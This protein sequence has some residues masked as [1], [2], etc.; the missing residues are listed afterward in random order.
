M[1]PPRR[2]R[3]LLLDFDG[4]LAQYSRPIR[5]ARLAEHAGCS[6][7]DVHQ[8][9][10]ASGLETAYDG[11]ELDTADYL[12][13]LGVA[14]GRPVDEATWLT[15]RV[16]ACR[17]FSEVVDAAA[18]L[19]QAMPVAI[20]TNNGPLITQAIEQIVP[21][22]VPALAGRVF[23]SAQFGGRKPQREVFLQALEAMGAEPRESLFI[24]DL[25]VNVRGARAA[26]LHAETSRDVRSFR[27]VLSRYQLAA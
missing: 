11:G 10:F 23:C 24:D 15:A 13:R 20:L 22:L 19:A 25:F 17:P 8:A 14:I 4:V 27:R 5:L 3:A 6:A 21:T 18:R 2:P 16:A 9:L 12:A 1:T 26:G 7:A